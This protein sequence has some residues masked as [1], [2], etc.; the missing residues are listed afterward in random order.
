M[1]VTFE[2]NCN[3]CSKPYKGYGKFFCSSA[4]QPRTTPP[5]V[6][7][8]KHYLWKGKEASYFAFHDWLRRHH[9]KA[10]KCESPS[11]RGKSKRFEYALLKGKEHGHSRENYWMLCK[12][13]HVTYD[14]TSLGEKH[15]NWQ[16]GFLRLCGNGC[17]KRVI[18]YRAKMCREC[19]MK[20]NNPVLARY[21]HE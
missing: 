13:C 12:S 21:N 11:C 8:E 10:N 3:T 15:W 17:G 5:S 16:G 7:G 4:C 9:G 19:R 6:S 1:P 18:N 2:R 14:E 20:V